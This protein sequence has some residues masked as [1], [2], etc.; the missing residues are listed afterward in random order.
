MT[1]V[2]EVAL[3]KTTLVAAVP[4]TVTVAENAPTTPQDGDV[5]AKPQLDGTYLT[6][7][8]S[9][10]RGWILL[11]AGGGGYGRPNGPSGP[12]LGMV[13]VLGVEF[14]QPVRQEKKDEALAGW[15]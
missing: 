1:A 4:P 14:N 2:S 8:W 9:A 3:P 10:D 6:S 13:R 5:W 7:I 12:R 11:G 15:A